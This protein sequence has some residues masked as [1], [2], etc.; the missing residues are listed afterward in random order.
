[1]KL[2]F[3][4]ALL[5]ILPVSLF[6]QDAATVKRQADVV[7]KALLNSDFK[8]VIANTYPKAV[9]LGGGKEQMLKIM[10]AGINQ[11]KS[12]G[13]SFE[14]IT[15]GSPGKFYKAGTEIHCLIPEHLIMK[16]S[17]GRMVATS[18]L[19]AISNDGGKNWSFLDMNQR[20]IN[21]VKQLFPNFNNNLIIPQPSQPVML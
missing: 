18:N 2:I 20:T 15:I 11:M 10:S 7:A 5:L 9:T 3:R 17:R 4:I 1:M 19:L 6:A 16:T 13:F 14:K 21:S 12:Q 8:T